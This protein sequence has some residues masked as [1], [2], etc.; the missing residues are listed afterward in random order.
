[1]LVLWHIVFANLKVQLAFEGLVIT[2]KFANAFVATLGLGTALEEFWG[3]EATAP[4][5]TFQL[6]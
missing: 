5:A 2:A 4:L 3:L 1:M 6:F